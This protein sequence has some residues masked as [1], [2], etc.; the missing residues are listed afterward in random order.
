M[1]SLFR[2]LLAVAMIFAAALPAR[3]DW[4]GDMQAAG[5]GELGINKTTGGALLGAALGGLLGG[6][7]GKGDG[8]L[9]ST[10]IGVLAGAWLGGQIGRQLDEADRMAIARSTEQ[11]VATGHEVAWRNPDTGVS[12]T[13][14]PRPLYRNGA[15]ETC[16]QVQHAVTVD[17]RTEQGIATLC[18][19]AKGNWQ[20]QN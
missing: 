16:R 6:Q 8:R 19:D 10:A 15:G 3:A 11:A 14:R 1:R 12:G 2:S 13:A 17:N 4:L 20:V 7:I 5:P 9:A 18:R